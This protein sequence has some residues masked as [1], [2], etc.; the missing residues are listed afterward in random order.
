LQK[1]N[2]TIAVGSST[3]LR[4]GNSSIAIKDYTFNQ[5]GTLTVTNEEFLYGK[6]DALLVGGG[7]GAAVYSGGGG[8]GVREIFDQILLNQSNSVSVGSG[9]GRNTDTTNCS[10]RHGSFGGNTTFLGFIA[11]GG[12]GGRSSYCFTSGPQRTVWNRNGGQSGNPTSQGE[13]N[14]FPGETD[15]WTTNDRL[16][17]DGALFGGAGGGAGGAGGPFLRHGGPGLA[18]T[19]FGGHYGG[20]GAGIGGSGGQASP[21]PGPT[22][23]NPTPGGI[24]GGGSQIGLQSGQIANGVNGLGGGG[25]AGGAGIF[26]SGNGGSGVVKVRVKPR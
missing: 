19:I 25:G 12:E 17:Q 24:G 1:D 14:K 5:S 7:G 4:Q 23:P 2:N 13:F 22:N 3:L 10:N 9:G 6:I 26:G 11:V 8:G 15:Q 21:G 16:A 18:S 20:G